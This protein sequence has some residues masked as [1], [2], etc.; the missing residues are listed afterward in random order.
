[1]NTRDYYIVSSDGTVI[2]ASECVLVHLTPGE[3]EAMS[4]EDMLARTLFSMAPPRRNVNTIAYQL[5]ME[6]V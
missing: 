2:E 5:A 3:A 1:M 4:N 6:D